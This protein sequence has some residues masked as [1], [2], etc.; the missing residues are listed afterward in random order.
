MFKD[1][2]GFVGLYLS[3]S[4]P[5][6]NFKVAKSSH[7]HGFINASK[8]LNITISKKDNR[9]REFLYDGAIIGSLDSMVSSFNDAASRRIC[10]D[11]VKTISFL[12][13]KGVNVPS[14]TYFSPE[15]GYN[16][17]FSFF[18][19]HKYGACVVKP[20]DG[21]AGK[22]ITVGV[23]TE[24]EFMQAWLLAKQS[25]SSKNSFILV[26]E[27]V[28][29]IDARV[30]VV[31]GKVVCAATRVPAHVIGNGI[32]TV[33]NLLKDKLIKRN[34]NP[35][36][37][38]RPYL[39]CSD[40]EVSP[41]F[42]PNKDECYF[43]T[44]KANIHMGG[45]SVDITDLISEKVKDNCIKAVDAI[46]GLQVAG[47][48]CLL[49]GFDGD[50]GVIIEVNTSCN[51]GMH[52]YPMYGK[53]RNPAFYILEDMLSAYQKK[54]AKPNVT[55]DLKKATSGFAQPLANGEK[56]LSLKAYAKKQGLAVFQFQ[57]KNDFVISNGAAAFVFSGTE[58][59]VKNR[60][61]DRHNNKFDTKERLRDIGINVPSGIRLEPNSVEKMIEF[62]DKS[63]CNSFVLKKANGNKGAYVYVDIKSKDRL[64]S[65]YS[66]ITNH[67]ALIEEFIPGNEHRVL[68]VGG[69][70]VAAAKR[71]R[72]SVVGNGTD[73]IEQLVSIKNDFRKKSSVHS[74]NLIV[75]DE[76]VDEFLREQSF[77]RSS[78]PVKGQEVYLRKVSNVS[79]GGDSCDVT[80]LVHSGFIEICERVWLAYNDRAI[81]G[82]DLICEDISLSPN[83]QSYGIIEVNNR[84]MLGGLHGSPIYG[85]GRQ[86]SKKIV[87]YLFGL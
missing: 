21:R 34:R 22:G 19:S 29:G 24:S 60:R 57:E 16:D 63:N 87:D 76:E 52:Y 25:L 17:A 80:D 56:F 81:Y 26:E 79:M 42:I 77:T 49:C 32:D 65:C 38:V 41:E 14:S 82:V 28:K 33:E 67:H 40:Y 35:Y 85:V 59:Y 10:A 37:L 12:K 46:P 8:E 1:Y 58:P 62:Y 43:L 53:A 13:R 50:A 15:D 66:K 55:F 78:V 69:R 84:P 36:H 5:N 54:T 51:F 44:N 75:L 72:A 83:E 48:D 31:N 23:K 27:E 86:V 71:L 7:L 64:L 39:S 2:T 68:V 47:V 61:H 4:F 3:N 70:V 9:V 30:I 18:K 11:K 20:S 74:K 45:E 73:M 6:D